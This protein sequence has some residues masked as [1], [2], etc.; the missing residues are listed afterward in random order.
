MSIG[1][2]GLGVGVQ[3]IDTTYIIG[4]TTYQ[5]ERVT[6]TVTEPTTTPSPTTIGPTA[7]P[8]MAPPRPAI[9]GRPRFRG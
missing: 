7:V 9:A 5:Y 6:S 8:G 4:D 2:S 3:T 1:T